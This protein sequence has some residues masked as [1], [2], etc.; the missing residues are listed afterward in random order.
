MYRKN[1][2]K[3]TVNPEFLEGAFWILLCAFWRGKMDL[4]P[5]DGS[6]NNL[7]RENHSEEHFQKY[8]CWK[9]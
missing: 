4:M 3:N 1:A 6:C 9:S 2:A 7:D 5:E 8:D